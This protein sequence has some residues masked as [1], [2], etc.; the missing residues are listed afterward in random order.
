MDRRQ[1]LLV[2]IRE[3]LR[4]LE[5]DPGIELSEDQPLISSGLLD[6]L[7]V[8]YL[9]EWV[10]EELAGTLDLDAT[11]VEREWDTVACILGFVESR[12]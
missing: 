8:L 6:S 5:R 4:E 10:D 2:L 1:R 9:A 12:V 7:A 11:D 3:R